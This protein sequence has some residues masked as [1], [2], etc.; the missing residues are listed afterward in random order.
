MENVV[1]DELVDA[2]ADETI[3]LR[4][5]LNAVK[6]ELRMMSDALQRIAVAAGLALP[7]LM[8]DPL[9]L[10]QPSVPATVIADA[11]SHAGSNTLG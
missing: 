8:S 11:S 4:A 5:E 9:R 2:V 1:Q 10:P 7:P 6:A 3:H